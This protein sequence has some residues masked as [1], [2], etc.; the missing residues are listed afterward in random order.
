MRRSAGDR[1]REA[2]LEVFVPLE[3][4]KSSTLAEAAA[5]HTGSQAGH[6]RGRR[7]I[8]V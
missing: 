1:L 7:V 6:A 2:L 4:A 8:L 5:A 3:H